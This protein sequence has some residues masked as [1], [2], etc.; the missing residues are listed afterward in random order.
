MDPRTERHP[1]NWLLVDTFEKMTGSIRSVQHE[2]E[3]Q[4]KLR[5]AQLQ[6]TLPGV[7]DHPQRQTCRW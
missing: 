3:T 6:S 7:A 1:R 5:T 4:V 2:L